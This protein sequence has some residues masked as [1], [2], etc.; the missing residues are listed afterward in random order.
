LALISNGT[1]SQY[2]PN[3]TEI[4]YVLL[5]EAENVSIPV[6]DPIK[7]WSTE[8]FNPKLRV[9]VMV[10]GWTTD[11]NETIDS[12]STIYEGYKTRGDSNF[13][14]LDSARYIDTLYTWSAFNT[15]QLG[16]YLG[17]ALAELINF[18]PLEKIHVV[19]KKL[20]YFEFN[21]CFSL[22]FISGHS[23]GAQISG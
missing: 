7:L 6:T 18:V 16:E 2:T 14:L 3:I 20:K 4:S 19:G 9:V 22:Y 15:N 13:I 11:I 5:T 17:D 21:I 10:T 23:L 1:K 8:L 12:A